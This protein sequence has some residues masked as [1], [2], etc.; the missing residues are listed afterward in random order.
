MGDK[1]VATVQ[2]VKSYMATNPE[3]IPNYMNATEFLK[4]EAL[5]TALDPRKSGD[6]AGFRH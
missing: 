4:D 5:V 1:T 6:P 2:K 3:F